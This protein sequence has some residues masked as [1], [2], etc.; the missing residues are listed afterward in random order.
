[1]LLA[2]RLEPPDLAGARSWWTRAA[3][4][5]HP[6]A[7]HN[8]GVLLATLLEPPDLAAARSWLTR[9]AEAGR[10]EAREALDELGD[11]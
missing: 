7:Q 4:A 5:G 8:L 9:A 1:V 2:D 3:E 6:G 11:G 10:A